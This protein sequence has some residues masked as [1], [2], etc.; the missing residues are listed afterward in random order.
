M[1]GFAAR[2]ALLYEYA[3]LLHVLVSFLRV[4]VMQ[5]TCRTVWV[6]F[7]C[8]VALFDTA[9]APTDSLLGG[10]RGPATCG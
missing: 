4:H 5:V 7:I 10:T 9:V 2:E 6:G 3:S 1:Q 8:Q